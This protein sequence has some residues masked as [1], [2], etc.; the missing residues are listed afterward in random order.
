MPDLSWKMQGRISEFQRTETEGCKT[1]AQI[2]TESSL[3]SHLNSCYEG[4]GAVLSHLCLPDGLEHFT[5]RAVL[6]VSIPLGKNGD[7]DLTQ[8]TSE[9]FVCFQMLL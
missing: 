1:A 6:M 3:F 4:A 5:D 8:L 2:Q 7:L 9:M